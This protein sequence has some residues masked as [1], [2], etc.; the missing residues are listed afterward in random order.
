MRMLVVA[1]TSMEIAPF[2]ER[3]GEG[4]SRSPRLS[5]YAC[6][7][8]DIDILTTGVG[9]VATAAWCSRALAQS[10]YDF[11]LN[12]GMCG[13]FDRALE[14]GQAVHVVSDRIA[15]LGAEA[16]E[17]F[18]TIQ[19]LGLLGDDEFPFT[20]G[21]LVNAVPPLNQAV[22]RLP[23]VHGIT[24][25]TA[26]GSTHSIATVTE[27]FRPQVESMEG[28]AFMYACLIHGIGFAQVR[29]VSNVVEPRNRS[30][31]KVSDAIISLARTA[32]SILEHA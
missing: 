3:L 14:P 17:T 31:W 24:V 8:H 10:R 9:M 5:G 11:A 26:H 32:L 12:L 29:T 4:S 21:R 20:G 28:A 1:A 19:E 2:V 15:D 22:S 27:R 23:S 6:S 7:G 13:T 30:A 18:L 16:G 25:N